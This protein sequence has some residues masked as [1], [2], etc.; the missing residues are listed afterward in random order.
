M[1]VMLVEHRMDL[2][3]SVCDQMTV[4]DSGTVIASGTPD[5]VRADPKVVEAYLGAAEEADGA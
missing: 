4:L 2:V 1:S 3:M 5:E